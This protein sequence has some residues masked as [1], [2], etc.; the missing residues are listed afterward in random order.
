LLVFSLVTLPAVGNAETHCNPDFPD[1]CSAEVKAGQKA[2]FSGVVVTPSLGAYYHTRAVGC[3]DEIDL[4]VT[5]TSSLAAAGEKLRTAEMK[6]DHRADL[7]EA[8][9]EGYQE[10]WKAGQPAWYSHPVVVATAAVVA[11]IGI[12]FAVK[13]TQE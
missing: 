10:G 8:R 7:V 2:P 3:Q 13:K 1:R 9:S 11:T 12:A 6:A 5:K 4:E